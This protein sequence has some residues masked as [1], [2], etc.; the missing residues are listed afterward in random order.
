MS[1]FSRNRK[2]GL[3]TIDTTLLKI[4]DLS[5]VLLLLQSVAFCWQRRQRFSIA[6][7][8]ILGMSFPTIVSAYQTAFWTWTHDLN[9]DMSS[10]VVVLEDSISSLRLIGG[11]A[12]YMNV[13]REGTTW[14]IAFPHAGVAIQF[15]DCVKP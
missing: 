6:M 9:R 8:L 10:D 13:V 3:N 1:H 12:P 2:G 7:L 14:R 5:F 15:S 11:P 4:T